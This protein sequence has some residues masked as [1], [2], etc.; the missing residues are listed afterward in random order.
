MSEPIREL[1]V[2][3][4]VTRL[5][6]ITT[7]AGYH[8]TVATVHRPSRLGVENPGDLDIIVIEAGEDPDDENEAVGYT[9][10]ILRTQLQLILRPSETDVTKLGTR[11]NRF[12]SD[13][14]KAILTDEGT[15]SV[16][17]VIYSDV[18]MWQAGD[19]GDVEYASAMLPIDI[20]IRYLRTNPESA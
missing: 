3:G 19:Q 8:Q 20:H 15:F 12:V 16:S 13:V 2:Q 5:A 9:A 10:R 1:A 6:T 17:G 7:V 4:L 18:G 11:V 14:E